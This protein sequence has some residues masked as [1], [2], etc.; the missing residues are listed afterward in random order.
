M[1]ILCFISMIAQFSSFMK[2]R[3][4]LARLLDIGAIET[5]CNNTKRWTDISGP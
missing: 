5:H 1:I 2:I 4:D 3:V